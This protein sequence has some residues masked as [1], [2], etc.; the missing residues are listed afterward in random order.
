MLFRLF[1]QSL[2]LLLAVA[3][4]E[5]GIFA[6]YHTELSGNLHWLKLLSTLL[7]GIRFDL[8]IS[9]AF[10]LLVTFVA[11]LAHRLLRRP[12]IPTMRWG[13]F[14]AG[15]L[16]IGIQ[17]ADLL[18]YG[19]AGRHLGYELKEWY[20]SGSSLAV[21]ALQTYTVPVLLQLILFIPLYYINRWLFG[22]GNTIH[23]HRGF[24]RT[25]LLEVQFVILL[26]LAVVMVR[27]GVQSVPLEP[28]HAQEIGDN[29]RAVLALN[30]GYNALFSSITPYS[31]SPVFASTPTAEEQT[32]VKALLRNSDGPLTVTPRP[33]ANV[34]FVLLESWSGAYMQSYGYD[35]PVT[36]VFDRL[37]REGITSRAMM[38]GGHR[39]TEGMFATFCSLQNPLGQTVAQSQLQNYDYHCLPRI[40]REEGYHTAFFQGTNANTSGTGAFAQLLGF[41]DSYGKADMPPGKLPDNSWG[42]HDPDIYDFTLDKLRAMPQPFMVGINTNST[43]DAQLPEGTAVSFGDN[44]P[45]YLSAL[46]YADGALGDFVAAVRNDPQLKDTVLVLLAD[47]PGLTPPDAYRASMIP[48]V[49]LAPGIELKELPG[50]LSQ[51]DIAP[52]IADLLGVPASREFTGQSVF[53]RIDARMA[54]Y[55][56]QGTLGWVSGMNVVETNLHQTGEQT[57]YTLTADAIPASRACGPGDEHSIRN[58]QAFTHLNQS[59]LF[60][61]Q[62]DKLAGLR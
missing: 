43:H 15:A 42:R 10:A 48:F 41:S 2:L 57:C 21:A 62:L 8:A 19:E 7:W 4:I 25:L 52:S 26:L 11:W 47:H 17:G 58:A 45:P 54:D 27:G 13:T 32:L 36:P 28:L 5:K 20:N 9:A 22:L 50:I 31:I 44:A 37:R 3:F 24:P 46:H 55:Y 40:A 49:I 61:G 33:R 16:L 29:H 56:H 59:L 60:S 30:G 51:R 53:R 1:L 6:L 34:I 12:L 35:K 23:L 39:T 18:Y 38:T 14:L